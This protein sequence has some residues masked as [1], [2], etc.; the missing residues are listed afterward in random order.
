MSAPHATSLSSIH[1]L[2]DSAVTAAVPGGQRR[3]GWSA[4]PPR[5]P[6]P[7]SAVLLAHPIKEGAAGAAC[8]L[9]HARKQRHGYQARSTGAACGR[10]RRTSSTAREASHFHHQGLQYEAKPDSSHPVFARKLQEILG[11]A[12]DGM[13][14]RCSTSLVADFRANVTPSRRAV[15]RWRACST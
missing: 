9:C 12:W 15:C 1:E 11:G 4:G 5:G 6:A 13:T 7:Q 3:D 2:L 10:C 8:V 14:C